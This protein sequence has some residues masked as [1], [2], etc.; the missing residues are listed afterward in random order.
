MLGARESPNA[1]MVCRRRP[2]ALLAGP[3][4]GSP[5]PCILHLLQAPS[6]TANNKA[7]NSL[8]FANLVCAPANTK[9]TVAG[10]ALF[11]L[12]L[13]T[14]EQGDEELFEPM[15]EGEP[16]ATSELPESAQERPIVQKVGAL[17]S[18]PLAEVAD[19]PV[20]AASHTSSASAQQHSLLG[21]A[22]A[23]VGAEVGG[24]GARPMLYDEELSSLGEGGAAASGDGAQPMHEASVGEAGAAAG[25]DGAQPSSRNAEACAEPNSPAGAMLAQPQLPSSR[26]AASSGSEAACLGSLPRLSLRT[27]SPRVSSGGPFN[28]NAPATPR[29][30][31]MATPRACVSPR[32]PSFGGGAAAGGTIEPGSPGAAASPK[33]PK[34]SAPE[35]GQTP[36]E[37]PV[38]PKRRASAGGGGGG[39]GG[40]AAGAGSR[41]EF[42]EPASPKRRASQEAAGLLSI[43]GATLAP[44]DTAAGVHNPFAD[45]RP[46]PAPPA[47]TPR[48]R[49]PPRAPSRSDSAG[50][51]STA[52]L[53]G[54][55]SGLGSGL[56]SGG[57]GSAAGSGSAADVAGEAWAALGLPRRSLRT[58][59][60]PSAESAR[61][62]SARDPPIP[63]S[64]GRAASGAGSG[65]GFFGGGGSSGGGRP[66]VPASPRVG[67]AARGDAGASEAPEGAQPKS[68]AALANGWRAPAPG[69]HA[70]SS[71]AHD[72]VAGW[73][74]HTAQFGVPL[75][76]S[77]QV[78]RSP[79]PS[80]SLHVNSVFA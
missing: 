9:R 77:Q 22:G 61:P 24:V 7:C 13:R 67:S 55:G 51:A 68:P 45:A 19:A 49:P 39:S 42:S 18:W 38:S 46:L 74:A 20:A 15:S 10:L 40:A 47:P 14:W 30:Y 48:P 75:P 65:A 58:R 72:A 28:S 36:P 6:V 31:V 80:L 59:V 23:M 60:S 34:R 56:V 35:G 54:V 44:C 2:G 63:P 66:P 79:P 12:R 37:S 4:A 32:P 16:E 57:V 76:P 69:Q 11:E 29:A 62:G 17:G 53:A 73:V 27:L 26:E 70:K 78:R 5:Q 52:P 3:L 8:L 43:G 1:E 33:P 71:A 21:E 64:P 50:T 41:H 25:S